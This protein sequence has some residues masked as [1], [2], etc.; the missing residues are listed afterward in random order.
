M[1]YQ[2][3]LNGPLEVRYRM[4]STGG[5]VSAG[6]AAD[7]AAPVT[8]VHRLPVQLPQVFV[9]HIHVKQ[10]AKGMLVLDPGGDALQRNGIGVHRKYGLAAGDSS[11][12]LLLQNQFRGE[13]EI[14]RIQTGLKGPADQGCIL[15]RSRDV[16]GEAENGNAV[17]A[18]QGLLTV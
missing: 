3:P 9:Q 8:A 1:A 15:H 6:S 11:D 12:D 14:Q 17:S 13:A 18:A 4:E 16:H 2:N 5:T 10:P 7:D